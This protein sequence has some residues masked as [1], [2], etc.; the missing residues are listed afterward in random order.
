M[1]CGIPVGKYQRS[2]SFTSPTKLRPSESIA[3]SRALPY[4]IIAHSPAACQCSSRTPPSVS[5]IFTPA[6]AVDTASSRTVTSRDQPP[7]CRR[8]C[9]SEKGYLNVC[10]PPASVL[11]GRIESLFCASSSA[12]F[13]PGSL[14]A[15][16][17]TGVLW[18]CAGDPAAPLAE[19]RLAAARAP[20]LASRNPRRENAVF[21]S[22]IS[23][24]S[25]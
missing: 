2:P 15:G 24:H 12:F 10:T 6:I 25:P 5:R 23:D 14:V 18:F 1:E 16:P 13:G 21:L 7:E 11:G 8:L 9:A 4:S 22:P 3:V 19:N 20:E 17:A